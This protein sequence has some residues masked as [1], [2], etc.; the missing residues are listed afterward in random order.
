MVHSCHDMNHVNSTMNKGIISDCESLTE[1]EC[2]HQG[3]VN[4]A[5]IDCGIDFS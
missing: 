1:N 5:C 2:C 4:N 3:I